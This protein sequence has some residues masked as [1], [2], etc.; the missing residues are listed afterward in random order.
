MP[1]GAREGILR[2]LYLFRP[3]QEARPLR[4]QLLGSGTMMAQVLRAQE[5]LLEKH[6]VAADA[7]SATSYG[8]TSPNA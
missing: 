1:E 8:L 4:A 5:I 6:G 7:W 2:G 3:S